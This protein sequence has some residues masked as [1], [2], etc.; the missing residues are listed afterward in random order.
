MFEEIVDSSSISL[1]LKLKIS[2][3]YWI[4][5]KK[6]QL[7]LL[8]VLDEV[9][10]NVLVFFQC[11]PE[12]VK[13]VPSVV[14]N[15]FVI[16]PSCHFFTVSLI[17]DVLVKA[18][19]PFCQ[20]L[21]NRCWRDTNF[22]KFVRQ[23]LQSEGNQIMEGKC[24]IDLLRLKSV[25]EVDEP[26]IAT[27]GADEEVLVLWLIIWK[28]KRFIKQNSVTHETKEKLFW[29]NYRHDQVLIVKIFSRAKLLVQSKISFNTSSVNICSFRRP[30]LRRS[31]SIAL[32]YS[33]RTL[34]HKLLFDSENIQEHLV[35]QVYL[36]FCDLQQFPQWLLNLQNLTHINVASNG[37]E[38]IPENIQ[39]LTNLNYFDASD[40][41]LTSLA[42][43]LFKLSQLRYLDVAGNFIEKIPKG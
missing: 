35:E 28:G 14:V 18:Y 22:A 11:V 37:I 25:A 9:A 23:I 33:F 2:V 43:G 24:W 31:M 29:E 40:N 34:D 38:K 17:Q 20:L 4:D 13:N 16:M 42:C 41:R 15:A 26:N 7:S 30:E 12:R 3:N 39:K 32:H 6:R 8:E 27:Q 21:K 1:V 36:K 10:H 5:H 19:Q